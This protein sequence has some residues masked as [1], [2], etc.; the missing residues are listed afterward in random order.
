MTATAAKRRA[1]T[2]SAMIML[3]AELVGAFTGLKPPTERCMFP[4]QLL[5]ALTRFIDGAVQVVR[6]EITSVPNAEY[7]ERRTIARDAV[8]NWLSGFGEPPMRLT[9][10]QRDWLEA[11][12][13]EAMAKMERRR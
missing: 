6:E 5:P 11:G 3:T 12:I 10:L 1:L 2:E 8:D 4:P 7:E 13:V 9:Q